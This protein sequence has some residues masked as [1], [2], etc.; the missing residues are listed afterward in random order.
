MRRHD[1]VIESSGNVQVSRKTR[2]LLLRDQ[3]G[4]NRYFLVNEKREDSKLSEKKLDWNNIDI[5]Y[6][7]QNN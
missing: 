5:K 4:F 1:I 3:R 6:I 7:Q 2:Y